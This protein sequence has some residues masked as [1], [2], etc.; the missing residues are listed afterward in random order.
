MASIGAHIAGALLATERM[1]NAF[2]KAVDYGFYNAVALTGIAVLCELCTI[3]ERKHK[4]HWAG[5]AIALGGFIFQTSLFLYTLAGVK[6]LTQITPSG[7]ILMILGWMLL[8]FF[9]LT[10]SKDSRSIRR[11]RF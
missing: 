4:F 9:T 3:S 10:A 6:W 5:Y 11:R 7:G 2:D 8:G 1:A